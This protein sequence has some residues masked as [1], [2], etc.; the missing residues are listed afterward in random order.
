MTPWR[1]RRSTVAWTRSAATTRGR[2][3]PQGS[4]PSTC[5]SMREAGTSSST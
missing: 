2:S 5:P 1:S 4:R 3:C